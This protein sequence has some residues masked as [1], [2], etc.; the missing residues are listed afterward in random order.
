MTKKKSDGR[1]LK[2]ILGLGVAAILF[3]PCLGIVAAIAIPA[4]VG[5]LTR[6]KTEE[7]GSNLRALFQGAAAYYEQEHVGADGQVRTHCLVESAS[8]PGQPG[9][10]QVAYPPLPPSFDALGF[11]ATEPLYYRYEIDSAGG[12]GHAAN[13][14]LYTF[15]AR[16]DLDGD[17]SL[18][19]YEIAS[20]SSGENELLRAPRIFVERPLE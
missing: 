7:A 8:T 14:V 1:A 3:V 16:G 18:S 15:R 4:F 6:A 9:P 5:Y 20:G 10:R 2:W 12:C 19:T 17:G 11:G 13:D